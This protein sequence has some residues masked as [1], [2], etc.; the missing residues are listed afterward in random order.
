[1]GDLIQL[2]PAITDATREIK[3]IEFDWVAE[4]AFVDIPKLH[5][6]INK[7][8]PIAHRRWVKNIFKNFRSG[9]ISKFYRELRSEKYDY[10]IDAQSNLKSG[11]VT[12]LSKGK[13]CGVN[14][15]SAREFGA[16]FAYDTTVEIPRNLHHVARMRKLFAQVLNYPEPTS[17]VDYGASTAALPKLDFALPEDF[18][19]IG[20]TASRPHKLWPENYWRELLEMLI[21]EGNNI[22]LPWHSQKEKDMVTNLQ[23]ISDKI[24]ILPKLSLLEKAAVIA[25]AKAAVS[26]DTG[27]A[28]LAA[29]FNIPNVVLYGPTSPISVGT[30]GFKQ[31]H[32]VASEPSCAPCNRSR[33]KFEKDS[34]V[35]PCMASLSPELVYQKLVAES[36]SS[37][38]DK[39]N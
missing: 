22:V 6:A 16:H 39:T 13:R 24:L 30:A 32:L 10:V 33:C 8:I 12:F 20:H 34:A 23:K 3:G 27:L 19:F 5:P 15:K 1:M 17:A 37:F 25:K 2:L 9:E 11:L 35:A 29:V 36:S 7:I 14:A 38:D 31:M 21:K 4:E 26:T 18:I 28:H